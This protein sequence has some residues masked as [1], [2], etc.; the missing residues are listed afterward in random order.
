MARPRRDADEAPVSD[1]LG[2]AS[3]AAQ[4]AQHARRLWVIAAAHVGRRDLAEDVVQE[5]AVIA[6]Q[7]LDQFAP[8]TSFGAWMAQIVRFTA[9]NRA[10]TERRGAAAAAPLAEVAERLA[11]PAADD[12]GLPVTPSGELAVDQRAFDDRVVAALASLSEVA[13]ACLLLQSVLEL[14][15]REIATTLEIPENTVASHVHRARARLREWLAEPLPRGA[16]P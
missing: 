7:K 16:T 12:A 2:P 14:S 4:F 10:R 9:Q 6:L 8:G 5:A 11:L 13:R 3:F 1:R 15:V